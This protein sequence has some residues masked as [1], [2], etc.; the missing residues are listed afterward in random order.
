MIKMYQAEVLSKFPIMQHF[1]F[2]SL[3]DFHPAEKAPAAAGTAAAGA[4]AA[5]E[6]A[7]V[8]GGAAQHQDAQTQ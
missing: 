3:L 8:A 7:G 1:L 4:T 6:A 5:G 2:G